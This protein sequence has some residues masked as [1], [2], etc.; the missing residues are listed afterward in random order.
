MK[1]RKGIIAIADVA[2][3]WEYEVLKKIMELGILVT[4]GTG[5]PFP[6]GC[7]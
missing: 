6:G 3:A 5:L 7:L 1:T 4:S 2:V